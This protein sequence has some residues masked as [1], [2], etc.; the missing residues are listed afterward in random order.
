[1]SCHLAICRVG[2]VITFR[3]DVRDGRG[4][5]IATGGDQVRV[6]MVDSKN[7]ANQAGHVIDLGNGSY[8]SSM[9]LSWPGSV[10]IRA[11][12]AY[13][14]AV[15][16]VHFFLRNIAKTV[17]PLGAGFVSPYDSEATLCSPFPVIQGYEVHQLCNFTDLNGGVPWYCG[18]PRKPQLGCRHWRYVFDTDFIT[19]MPITEAEKT[20]SKCVR[21]LRFQSIPSSLNIRVGPRGI[22]PRYPVMPRCGEQSLE[23]SWT[24]S[25]PQ[26]YFMNQVWY[27]STCKLPMIISDKPALD[28]CVRDTT[29]LF[30]GDSNLRFAFAK[31]TK[32]IKCT[33][34]S[35]PVK[36]RWHKPLR[37]QHNDTNTD[38]H[39]KPHGFPFHI[40]TVD[41]MGE[42][43]HMRSPSTYI[44][45]IPRDGRFVVVV[46]VYPHYSFHHY[47]VFTAQIRALRSSVERVLARNPLVK[48]VVRGAHAIAGGFDLEATHYNEVLEREFRG[49]HDK[50]FFLQTWDMTV[51]IENKDLHPPDYIHMELLR[52]VLEYV[53]VNR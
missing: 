41:V 46:H 20:W 35:G 43:T 45:E 33:P 48:L 9:P 27:P 44:D 23:R 18:K 39:W 28:K 10:H 31:L 6:W 12:I 47:S 40:G 16:R 2:D 38:I 26:G 36:S 24:S 3:V 21:E 34:D 5:A 1:M 19:P 52:I 22:K 51:A 42:R 8:V 11:S 53:C 25:S 50:V 30:L 32:L 49:L 14:S 37:C 7:K 4:R 17:R 15:I 13:N 29:F